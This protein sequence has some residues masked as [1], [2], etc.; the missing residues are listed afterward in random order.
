MNKSQQNDQWL[1]HESTRSRIDVDASA[2]LPQGQVEEI[3]QEVCGECEHHHV[4]PLGLKGQE[5]GLGRELPHSGSALK[6]IVRAHK[7]NTAEFEQL[8]CAVLTIECYH[9][10]EVYVIVENL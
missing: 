6:R 2:I 10:V 9:F 1:K 7:R 8:T 5:S 4:N 3:H